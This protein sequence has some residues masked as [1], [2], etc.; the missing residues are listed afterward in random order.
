MKTIF[1]DIWSVGPDN[2]MA[3]MGTD[4]SSGR[5][6][7]LLPPCPELVRCALS[8]PSEV[9]HCAFGCDRNWDGWAEVAIMACKRSVSDL[10]VQSFLDLLP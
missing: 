8:A 9:I 4:T 7:N 6:L 5:G 10:W 3:W 2:V 1:L